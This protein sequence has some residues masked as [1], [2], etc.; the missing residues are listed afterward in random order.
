MKVTG[1]G[2]EVIV[3]LDICTIGAGVIVE[4]IVTGGRLEVVVTLKVSVTL[5]IWTCTCVAVVNCN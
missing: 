3:K 1:G 4:M 2:M 5:E